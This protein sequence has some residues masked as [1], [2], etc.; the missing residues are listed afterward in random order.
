M[1]PFSGRGAARNR[2]GPSALRAPGW[3]ET[4]AECRL[5]ALAELDGAA[6]GVFDRAV[7]G[8]Q[9]L[10]PRPVLGGD[11][12]VAGRRRESASSASGAAVLQQVNDRQRDL[13]FAQVAADRLA[14]RFGARR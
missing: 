6:V 2:P 7:L 13:A 5:A 1:P 4:S 3:R 11:V 9:R 8:Q 14:E 10:D 12:A